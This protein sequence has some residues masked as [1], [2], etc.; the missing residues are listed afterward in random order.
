MSSSPQL[1]AASAAGL[2]PALPPTLE[3]DIVLFA[4]DPTP[5]T[6]WNMAFANWREPETFVGAL[7]QSQGSVAETK[8][9]MADS[10]IIFAPDPQYLD[11]KG[12]WGLDEK[13]GH[14][15]PN[16]DDFPAWQPTM[17]LSQMILSQEATTSGFDIHLDDDIY[18]E[19]NKN[20]AVNVFGV[21]LV[22]R[23]R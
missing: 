1:S 21:Q 23:F 19:A 3:D 11:G 7:Q 22:V 18:V 2:I 4:G 15:E 17:D 9:E 14:A 20:S 16:F 12:E 10:G 13:V 5:T 6:P 8:M